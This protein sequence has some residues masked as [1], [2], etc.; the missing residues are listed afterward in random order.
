MKQSRC[1]LHWHRSEDSL[2]NTWVVSVL[3]LLTHHHVCIVWVHY[4]VCWHCN[5]WHSTGSLYPVDRWCIAL[6][7]SGFR[8]CSG[9][10]LFVISCLASSVWPLECRSE[11]LNTCMCQPQ[12]RTDRSYCCPFMSDWLSDWL[13]LLTQIWIDQGCSC[14]FLFAGMLLL[15]FPFP[16]FPPLSNLF[17]VVCFF[18]VVFS[19]VVRVC[20]WFVFRGYRGGSPTAVQAWWTCPLG[21]VP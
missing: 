16:Y 15:P 11:C 10:T 5:C 2:S 8:D 13:N 12:R 7:G 1:L 9:I 4:W 17:C 19:F 6:W 18:W 20:F 14:K 21:A 3:T